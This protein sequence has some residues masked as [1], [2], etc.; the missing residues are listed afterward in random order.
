VRGEAP[1]AREG[2]AAAV[3]GKRLFV[4]GGCGKSADNT[5]DVYYNDLY[6]LDTGTLTFIYLS[7]SLLNFYPSLSWDLTVHI[8]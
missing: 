3:I 5:N 7:N 6:I 4:F 2:H 1:E 8:G